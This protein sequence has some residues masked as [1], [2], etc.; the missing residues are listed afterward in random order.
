MDNPIQRLFYSKQTFRD[1]DGVTRQPVDIRPKGIAIRINLL[2]QTVTGLVERL[3]KFT[4]YLRL[5]DIN[6]FCDIL[7]FS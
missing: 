7:D 4:S 1:S 3:R 5:T 2:V 6:Q